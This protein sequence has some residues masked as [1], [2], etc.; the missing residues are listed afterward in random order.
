MCD[1]Y[2]YVEDY[3]TELQNI[4]FTK[5]EQWLYKSVTDLEKQ[6]ESKFADTL[7]LLD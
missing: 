3:K 4:E 2:E 7:F 5:A 6:I 1:K